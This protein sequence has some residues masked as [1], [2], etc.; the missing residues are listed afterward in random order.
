VTLS[1][2]ERSNLL[3]PDRCFTERVLR[4]S[5]RGNLQRF[6]GLRNT[7]RQGPPLTISSAADAEHRK[8]VSHRR[9]KNDINTVGGG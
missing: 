5:L 2:T 3:H 8:L 9:H 7:P 1:I 6:A 4:K